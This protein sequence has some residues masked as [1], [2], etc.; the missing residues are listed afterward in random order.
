MRI[1]WVTWIRKLAA[2][3]YLAVI[4]FAGKTFYEAIPDEMYVA[5]G[6]KVSY[7]FQVPVSVVLKDTSAEAFEN[8]APRTGALGNTYAS[9][10]VTCKLF[11]I[12]PVK[13]VEVMLVDSESVYASGKTIGIYASS[14]G[15]LVIGTGA[16]EDE[17]GKEQCPAEN[18]VKGG[19]YIISINGTEVSEKE[20][21][22]AKVNDRTGEKKVLGIR[23]DGAYLEV[24][25][26]PVKSSDG[27]YKLGIW[28]RDDI[29]GVGTLT[30]FTGD[31]NFG[32]LGHAVSDGDTGTMFEISTG[33][34]YVADII[35]IRKGENGNPGEI[36]GIINYGTENRLGTLTDNTT[37][38][39]HGMLDGN[40]E[41][42]GNSTCLEVAYKQEITQG[43]AYILSSV[44]GES[45]LYEITIEGVDYSGR[46]ENKG[47]LFE[48][49][50]R[51]LIALTGGIVQ[52]MSGS[53][54]IQNGKIVGAVT[55]VFISDATKGYGI[56]IEK[57][58]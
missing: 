9:Y 45:R 13:D 23:R 33:A 17:S 42:L 18:L 56:F 41:K 57:M 40:L 27:S 20:E 35:G 49:R 46:E 44:S 52:G 37:L 7:D 16:V 25:L 15:I 6:Q 26:T 11:G 29:A 10:T 24:A 51:E 58:L 4:A 2:V 54:I 38:G 8:Q 34:I 3:G 22:T 32:A 53:P 21:L 14:D 31:G 28:V 1:K 36:S 12:F 47:I 30:Y 48:V 39:I 50:D 5:V 19:D 43:T 55:H